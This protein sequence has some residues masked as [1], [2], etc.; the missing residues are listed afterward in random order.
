MIFHFCFFWGIISLYSRVFHWAVIMY[1]HILSN[2]HD[3]GWRLGLINERHSQILSALKSCYLWCKIRVSVSMTSEWDRTLLNFSYFFQ[4]GENITRSVDRLF[5]LSGVS[6]NQ[7]LLSRPHGNS[8]R[9]FPFFFKLWNELCTCT[10]ASN[11]IPMRTEL[12]FCWI[13]AVFMLYFN[14]FSDSSLIDHDHSLIVS[15]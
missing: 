13:L 2:S 5:R 4:Q 11:N 7:F 8:L 6:H 15:P 1:L 9:F 12:V 14:M 3:S 10:H